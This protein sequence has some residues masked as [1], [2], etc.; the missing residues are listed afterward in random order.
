VMTN[1]PLCRL[2]GL[3][4]ARAKARQNAAVGR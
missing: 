4:W 3:P 2:G 1:G